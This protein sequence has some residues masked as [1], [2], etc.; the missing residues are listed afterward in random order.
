[1]NLKGEGKTSKYELEEWSKG[2]LEVIADGGEAT[3]SSRCVKILI[4]EDVRGLLIYHMD[5]EGLE[6]EM[7]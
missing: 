4:K 3:S 2:Q 6:I 1:M 7:T 5:L